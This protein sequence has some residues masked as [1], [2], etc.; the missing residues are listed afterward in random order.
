MEL[1]TCSGLGAE[2]RGLDQAPFLPS[3]SLL[4]GSLFLGRDSGAAVCAC[5]PLFSALMDKLHW[6]GPPSITGV[7]KLTS[8]KGT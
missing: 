5:G 7:W 8:L 3:R 1:L 2:T 4:A 6:R